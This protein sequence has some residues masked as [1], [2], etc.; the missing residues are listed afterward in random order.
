MSALFS[1]TLWRSEDLRWASSKSRRLAG[2][3]SI[4]VESAIGSSLILVDRTG[5]EGGDFFG[6][7]EMGLS[8]S[9]TDPLVAKLVSA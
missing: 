2:L 1:C 9:Q 8:P 3:F 5:V 6:K 7:K 4:G